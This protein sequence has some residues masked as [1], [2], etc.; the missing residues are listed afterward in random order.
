[1]TSASLDRVVIVGVGLAGLRAAESLREN[2]HCG[3]I[4]IVGEETPYC[5]RGRDEYAG[6]TGRVESAHWIDP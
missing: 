4:V 1:M 2:G 3:E 6:R 5:R